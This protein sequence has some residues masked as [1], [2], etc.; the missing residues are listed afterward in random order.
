MEKQL[1]SGAG[2]SLDRFCRQY[3][4]VQ[5][6]LD[7]P[8]A[9]YLRDDAF[10]Q[11]LCARLANEG[12]IAVQHPPP[13]RYQARV[14][15]ELVKRIEQSIQNWEDEGVSD[16]LVNYLASLLASSLPS[17]ATSAQQKA[18]VT[19]TLSYLSNFAESTPTITLL[20]SQSIIAG[21]GTT[22]LRTWDAALHLGNYLCNTKGLV[23]GKSIL[24]LGAGT[25]WL[26]ILCAKHLHA[27]YVLATDG[28][29]DV[30]E[31][32]ETNIYLNGLRETAISAR[33]LKW[34]QAL[35]GAE[36]AEWNRG[37]KIDLVLGADLAYYESGIPALVATIMDLSELFPDVKII[38]SAI[39]RNP[40]T[41]ESFVEKCRNNGYIIEELGFEIMEPALQQGPFYS[42]QVP[43]KLCHIM[44]R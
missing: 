28:S 42:D 22:G 5:T 2:Q 34:G 40:K 25:G 9:Q 30:V 36:Q 31:S 41:F 18:H 7:Y 4:Q 19:Y 14:L 35:V 38:I 15:K 12:A 39:V 32:L 37:R 8:A 23:E 29:E 16:D 44:K 13:R 20:E 27:S 10:Q 26:S 43:I 33:D 21:S 6:D 24:E 3:L 11:A 1:P 17:E